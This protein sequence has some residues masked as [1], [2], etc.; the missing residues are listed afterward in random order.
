M[1]KHGVAKTPRALFRLAHR[2][3]SHQSKDPFSKTA[4]ML[5][6]R[7]TAVVGCGVKRKDWGDIEPGGFRR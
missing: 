5:Q 3:S 2:M 1:R 6:I 4:G 7:V